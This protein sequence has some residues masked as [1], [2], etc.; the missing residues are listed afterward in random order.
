MH[1][2]DP[3]SASPSPAPAARPV[4]HVACELTFSVEEHATLAV[5]VA[6]AGTAGPRL[7]ERL[8][9][10]VDGAPPHR[11]VAEVAATHG[12]RIHVV[13]APEGE[14]RISYAASVA[15]ADVPDLGS[16]RRAAD[17]GV[18]G[19]VDAGDLGVDGPVDAEVLA[20][21]RQSRYCPSDELAGWASTGLAH[22]PDGPDLAR[23][24][25]GWVHDHLD[26]VLGVSRPVDTAVDTLLAG[27]GACRDFAHLTAALCRARGVP[28]RVV[29]VYA[30]GLAPMDFHAVVEARTPA[31]WELV[32][33]T[34][35][36]PRPSLV[37]IATG[38]DAA[39]TAFA[40]TL[41]GAAEL[42]TTEIRAVVDGDLP[43]DDHGAPVAIA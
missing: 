24:I 5:Q 19:P 7:D 3:P 43:V 40:T 32:D 25:G 31:G 39:D 2:S 6:A 37:R 4:R 9:V 28:A 23:R 14:L 20:A 41:R 42:T 34:R 36:A 26:Y 12:G 16:G 18:D 17:R 21:L 35:L 8:V 1:A 22:L 13:H 29:A 15:G 30:P 10:T 11:P 33:A 27:A 38:R